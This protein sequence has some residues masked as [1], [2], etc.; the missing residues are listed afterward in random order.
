MLSFHAAEGVRF[1]I[2]P[3]VPAEVV[4][5][6]VSSSRRVKRDSGARSNCMSV[7]YLHAELQLAQPR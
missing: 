2:A 5:R 1:G 4:L 7:V 6:T 3:Y